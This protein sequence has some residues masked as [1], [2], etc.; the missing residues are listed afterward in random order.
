MAGPWVVPRRGAAGLAAVAVLIL[1][2]ATVALVA[3]R[4]GG[5]GAD[6]GEGPLAVEMRQRIFVPKNIPGITN[7]VGAG[8]VW[9]SWWL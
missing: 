5:G 4:G 7:M 2:G 3:V 8:P 1:A 6:W 9:D